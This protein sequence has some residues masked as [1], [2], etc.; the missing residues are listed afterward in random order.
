MT[1][2]GSAFLRDED[3]AQVEGTNLPLPIAARANCSCRKRYETVANNLLSGERVCWIGLDFD[4]QHRALRID[5]VHAHAITREV[6]ERLRIILGQEQ[7]EPG[8]HLQTLI[9]R[10]RELDEDS[11][12]IAPE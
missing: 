11:P 5:A 6:A 12:P 8:K 2:C 10:L 1:A 3:P 7:P 9:N 4:V